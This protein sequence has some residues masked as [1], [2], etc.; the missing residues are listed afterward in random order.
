MMVEQIFIYNSCYKNCIYR[1]VLNCS[2]FIIQCRYMMFIIYEIK[3]L[4]IYIRVKKRNEEQTAIRIEFVP[5]YSGLIA[6]NK[7]RSVFFSSFILPDSKKADG[8]ED[9]L[10]HF[11]CK[12]SM[13]PTDKF[14]ALVLKRR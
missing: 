2:I 10:F 7:T 12:R 1:T 11:M 4:K 5:F 3:H 9:Y 6:K 13:V 8:I 14:K